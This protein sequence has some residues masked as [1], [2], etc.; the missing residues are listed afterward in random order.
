M[1][2]WAPVP[3]LATPAKRLSVC[4]QRATSI[5]MAK[6]AIST[7]TKCSDHHRLANRRVSPDRQIVP[8]AAVEFAPAG[9]GGAA[10]PLFEEERHVGALTLVAK[11]AYSARVDG[12]GLGAGFTADDDP[13]DSVE[14]EIG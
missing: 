3:A 10:A 12:A 9:F 7:G 11:I 4:I 2:Y 6:E 14:V 1:E 8:G 5:M 13:A